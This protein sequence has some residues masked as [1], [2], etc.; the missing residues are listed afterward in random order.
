MIE[1]I[2]I[3]ALTYE[4]SVNSSMRCFTTLITTKNPFA[5]RLGELDGVIGIIAR[6]FFRQIANFRLD[7]EL[8]PGCKLLTINKT[9]D[10][11][12]GIS[13]ATN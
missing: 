9:T 1:T 10:I 6:C 4:T 3:L 5:I 2:W 8:T 11:L 7:L 13:Y 12:G